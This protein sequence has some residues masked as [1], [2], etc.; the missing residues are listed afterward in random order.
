MGFAKHEVYKKAL[1][2]TL[3]SRAWWSFIT[4]KT[5]IHHLGSWRDHYYA[6]SDWRMNGWWRIG[7]V[8]MKWKTICPWWDQV[9]SGT[10]TF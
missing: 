6:S 8:H 4:L 10:R 5:D 3:S 2:A 9:S 7:A 1:H